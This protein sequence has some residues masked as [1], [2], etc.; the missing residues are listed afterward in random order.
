MATKVGFQLESSL[1]SKHLTDAEFIKGGYLVVSSIADRDALVVA[2]DTADGTIIKGSL[3][4]CQ[5]DNKFY[6]FDDETGWVELIADIPGISSTNAFELNAGGDISINTIKDNTLQDS[7]IEILTA[8]DVYIEGNNIQLTTS[9]T[10]HVTVNNKEVLTTDSVAYTHAQSAHAPS[11]AEKN[12]QSDWTVTDTSSDAFIKNKP[13][14]GTAAA[15]SVDTSISAASTSANLPTSAAVAAF[16]ES[17]GYKTTDNNTTYDLAASANSTNGNVQINLTAGGSGSG[18]DS[19]IVEG[20]G[21]TTVT[22]DANGVITINTP[23]L[24]TPDIDIDSSSTN[25]IANSAVASALDNKS[26]IGHSHT[27]YASTVSVTGTGNAITAISQSGNTIT[28][29]KG[30]FLTAND[31]ASYV[32]S[33]STEALNVNYN[34]AV[35]STNNPGAGDTLYKDKDKFTYNPS[36][37]NLS[38]TYFTENGTALANKY[39]APSTLSVTASASSTSSTP[40]ASATWDA[41]NKKINFSFGLPKG[42]TGASSEWF[43]GTGITGTE[44]T[45]QIFSGSGITSATVGDM[46]LNNST[47]DVYRCA[48]AGNASTAKWAYVGNIKGATGG[49]GPTGPTGAVSSVSITGNGNALTGVTGTSALTFTRGTFVVPDDLATVATSGKYAD[50]TDTPSVATKDNDGLMSKTDKEHHNQMWNIWA[51]DGT[52]DTL[53]NKVEEVLKA[54]ENAPEGTNIVNALASKSDVGHNHKATTAAVLTGVNASGTDTFVKTIDGGYGSLTSDTT[55]DGIKYV[56][57]VTHTAATLSGATTFNTDA[58]K[59]VALSASDTSTDGPAYVES[60]THTAAT[61]GGTKTFVT[62]VTTGSGSLTANDTNTGIAVLTEVNKGD[63]TPAGT[64][65]LT[66][67]TAPSMGAATTKYLSAVADITSTNS[68]SSS[69]TS[70]TIGSYSNGVLTIA[71][72]VNSGA[73]THTYDKATSV[74]LTANDATAAGRIQYVQSQGTFNAGTT[75]KASAS[76]SGTKTNALVTDATTKYLHHTH[77]SASSAGTGTVTI[78]GGSITPV[79]KYMKK[80]TAAA[81]TGTVGISGGSI[82]PSTKYLHHTHTAAST[83]TTGSAVTSVASNGTVNAVT[84]IADAEN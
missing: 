23:M 53:V 73:H 12:V 80:T 36:T 75:P 54:F 21:S 79:T 46:Y 30:T 22:T 10:G 65:S 27:N 35:M 5:A 64:I 18:T 70:G 68:G 50:L 61:L 41:A 16:V 25:A 33:N 51:A 66:N 57:S 47:Y 59:D 44:T 76:F 20:A 43:F 62:G 17:K 52:D 29:T 60:V 83:A 71:T 2:T 48:T 13:S 14:L 84:A 63:Y 40:T 82:T 56:E 39:L 11:D 37:G 15:K 34:V 28:A 45:A 1:A 69:G 8:G 31:S 55:T 42:D 81:S 38:A 24:P 32:K 74:T 67:G 78:S 19:I 7:T 4:Y 6:Q 77:T 9:D 26:D 3:C 72:T 49:T 58:I